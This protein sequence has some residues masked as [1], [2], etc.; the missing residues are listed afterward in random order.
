[1]K[2]ISFEPLVAGS[3]QPIVAW[4]QIWGRFRNLKKSF[5]G[6]LKS[7]PYINLVVWNFYILCGSFGHLCN[8][9]ILELVSLSTFEIWIT[10]PSFLNRLRLHRVL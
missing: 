8:W 10:L 3:P 9:R 1:M 6:G 4:F 7:G 5:G 2:T